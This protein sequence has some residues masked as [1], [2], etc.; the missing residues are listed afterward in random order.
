MK[1]RSVRSSQVDSLS[2]TWYGGGGASPSGGEHRAA[3][4]R[5]RPCGARSEAD[6]GP[7]LKQVGDRALGRVGDVVER[8][9]DKE[10]LGLGLQAVLVLF[11]SVRASLL[12]GGADGRRAV[13]GRDERLALL[14]LLDHVAGGHVVLDHLAVDRDRVGGDGEGGLLDVGLRPRTSPRPSASRPRRFGSGAKGNQGEA[15]EGKATRIM[16]LAAARRLNRRAIG[17]FRIRWPA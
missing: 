6:P 15:G 1:T 17:H 12:T 4:G 13:V 3:R 16:V 11:G 14:L 2:A 8:V 7:P 5:P 9:G 10:H